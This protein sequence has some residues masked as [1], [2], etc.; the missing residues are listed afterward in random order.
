MIP[1]ALL[2][3]LIKLSL[4]DISFINHF[5]KVDINEAGNES[6]NTRTQKVK[7]YY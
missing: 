4:S 3:E 6:V 5:E 1:G 7:C 2:R